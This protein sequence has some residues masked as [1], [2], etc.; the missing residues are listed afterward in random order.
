[1]IKMKCKYCKEEMS[2]FEGLIFWRVCNKC[3]N[4]M[5]VVTAEQECNI[6]EI[7]KRKKYFT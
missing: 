5:Q 1:M 7:N 4:T 2:F 3:Y 6:D